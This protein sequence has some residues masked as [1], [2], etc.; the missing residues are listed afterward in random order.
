MKRLLSKIILTS[1]LSLIFILPAQAADTYTLDPGHTYVLWHIS[2]FGFSKPSGKWFA[3]G[4]I[5]YDQTKPQDSKINVTI[6]TAN[7]VTGIPKLDEHL[8]DKDFFDVTQ[9]PTAT[10]VSDQMKMT[11]KSTAKVSGTLTVHGVSKPVTLDVTINKIGVSPITQ[12]PTIGFTGKTTLKR[13]DFGIS[14]YL[15]G[16]SDEVQIEIEGEANKPA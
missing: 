7:M 1:I 15:P 3:E 10:F 5:L 13:S 12:K 8:K 11:G 14:A 6:N 2:H 9:F 16:L 4:T